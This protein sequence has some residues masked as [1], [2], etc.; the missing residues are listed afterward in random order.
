MTGRAPPKG[1]PRRRVVGHKLLR[2]EPGP[3]HKG[4]P[5]GG[6]TWTELSYKPISVYRYA[7]A[8]GHFEDRR[9]TRNN[10][11]KQLPCAACKAQMIRLPT[12]GTHERRRD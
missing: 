8:C 12:K 1:L 11:P 7:L 2:R 3:E 5:Q 9:K 4:K 6:G 10:F